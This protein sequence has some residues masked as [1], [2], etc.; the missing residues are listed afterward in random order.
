[1][2]IIL[3]SEKSQTQ[4]DKDYI[5]AHERNLILVYTCMKISDIVVESVII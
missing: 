3:L 4:E 5:I 2:E 1:M